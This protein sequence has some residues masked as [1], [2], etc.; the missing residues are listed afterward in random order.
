LSTDIAPG[1]FSLD[2]EYGLTNKDIGCDATAWDDFR[3]NMSGTN[4]SGTQG[5]LRQR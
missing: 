2:K 3:N 1:E 5:W 4:M